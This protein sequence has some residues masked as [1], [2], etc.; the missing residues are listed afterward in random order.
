MFFQRTRLFL[1][2]IG[3]FLIGICGVVLDFVF[4]TNIIR[5]IRST[6]ESQLGANKMNISK[7]TLLT[8]MRHVGH[9]ALTDEDCFVILLAAAVSPGIMSHLPE[10]TED[11]LA[12]RGYW[13]RG[14]VTSKG[15]LFLDSY[16]AAASG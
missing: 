9:A 14:E 7:L 10:E 3:C 5:P 15:R 2:Q 4:D 8:G 11:E 12:A 13:D 6:S 16:E 1:A